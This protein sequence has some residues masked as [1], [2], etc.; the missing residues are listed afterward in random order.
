MVAETAL[1]YEVMDDGDRPSYVRLR[2]ASPLEAKVREPNWR[3]LDDLGAEYHALVKEGYGTSVKNRS[4]RQIEIANKIIEE[5][6]PYIIKSVN[7]LVN[8]GIKISYYGNKR[9]V[10][11][12]ECKIPLPE[13]IEEG[14]D[15]VIKFLH[16]Y[17][18]SRASLSTF[19]PY[20]ILKP[21]QRKAAK[22]RARQE[23]S[24][25]DIWGKLERSNDLFE[26][27]Y[28]KDE[29]DPE[30]TNSHHDL[31]Q[32][33][34]A[35]MDYLLPREREI[36][37]QRYGVDERTHQAIAVTMNISDKRVGQLERRALQKIRDMLVEKEQVIC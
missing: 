30:Q 26:N 8:T 31:M 19:I 16:R 5:S 4:A 14:I 9:T 36:L 10:K 32:K 24:F 25:V 20:Q 7:E 18:P 17:D 27:R 1:D 21:L 11:I 2:R 13:L 28:L 3:E 12:A 34:Y 29:K 15:A 33:V 6:K 37:Q 35:A 23:R 22:E